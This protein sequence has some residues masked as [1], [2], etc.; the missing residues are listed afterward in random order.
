MRDRRN[1]KNIGS[2]P[3]RPDRM[4]Q[5][6]SLPEAPTLQPVCLPFCSHALKW[7]LRLQRA[8]RLSARP[9]P[10]PASSLEGACHARSKLSRPPTKILTP[11]SPQPAPPV[12]LRGRSWGTNT[13]PARGAFGRIERLPRCIR[14]QVNSCDL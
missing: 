14:D 1:G 6:C 7:A 12:R 4:A 3:N 11:L 9:D 8:Y 10:S 2:E 13:I 5:A